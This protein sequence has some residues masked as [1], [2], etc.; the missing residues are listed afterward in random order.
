MDIEQLR[1][2]LIAADAAGDTAAA[3][4][5]AAVIRQ[6]EADASAGL[7]APN[8]QPEPAGG[9]SINPDNVSQVS[10]PAIA[11]GGQSILD[12]GFKDNIDAAVIAGILG[13]VPEG[14]RGVDLFNYG[15]PTADRYAAMRDQQRGVWDQYQQDAPNSFAAGQIGAGIMQTGG[16]NPVAAGTSLLKTMGLMGLFGGVEG[17]AYN[18]GTGNADTWGEL[19]GDATA[20]GILGTV[21][22]AGVVPAVAGVR[23]LLDDFVGGLY[24]SARNVARPSRAGRT[25]A[26]AMQRTD[27]PLGDI[28][29]AIF[30]AHAQGQPMFTTADAMGQPGQRLLAGVARS[31]GDG[32][33]RILEYLDQRQLGQ[34]DRLGAFLDD[35]LNT[36]ETAAQRAALLERERSAAADVN[37]PA[38]RDV[39]TPVDIQGAL[40][41]IDGRLSQL[42]VPG[43]EG[44]GINGGRLDN[45]LARYRAQL[46]VP[47]SN[48][49]EGVAAANL[50]DFSRVLEVKQSISDDIGEA[51]R[52]GRGNEARLLTELRNSLDAALQRSSDGYRL[53]NDTFRAQSQAL[54]AIPLGAEVAAR[55]GRVE[56]AL[57]IY[58]GLPTA[59]QPTGQT[60]PVPQGYVFPPDAQA[61]FRA[62]YGDRLQAVIEN[63]V[64]GAN[65]ARPLTTPKNTAMLQ[66]MATDPQLLADRIAREQTM[67]QTQFMAQGGSPTANLTQDIADVADGA[68]TIVEGLLSPKQTLVRM[69][70]TQ[71]GNILTGTNEKTRK[72]I[73]DALLSPDPR[74]SIADLMTQAALSGQ[75]DRFMEAFLRQTGQQGLLAN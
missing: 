37:Y 29:Q 41:M 13:G 6:M 9:V 11:A 20:G 42:T 19:A 17:A 55:K 43:M 53:A 3:T 44:A 2:A 34:A 28:E 30:Q 65:S 7:A 18:A 63:Q 58:N 4:A 56:D 62:G 48:L 64:P 47:A 35:A 32:S 52:A 25:I 12:F 40:D 49:P 21:A 70:G 22:G 74:T 15:T 10:I 51:V 67:F 60:L 59:Q 31:P 36:P 8:A 16:L 27:K 57:D 45:L 68:P 1:K 24:A 50:S 39:A 5:L 26:R 66:Q 33:R 38:A 73:A 69:I 72:L 71:A 61:A 75:T 46:A 23:G 54:D 14:D